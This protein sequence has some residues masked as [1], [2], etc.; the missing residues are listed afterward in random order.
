LTLDIDRI[1]F[2]APNL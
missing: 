2:V 1:A